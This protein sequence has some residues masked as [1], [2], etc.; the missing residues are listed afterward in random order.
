VIT[1]LPGP[2][3]IP[4]ALALDL[5]AHILDSDVDIAI[6]L[7]VAGRSRL[8]PDSGG[9]D[10]RDR[11]LSGHSDRHQQRGAALCPY[12][13]I[14]RLGEAVGRFLAALDKRVLIVSGDFRTSRRC[15]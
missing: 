4:G 10:R 2:L 13:R 6:S 8:H 9:T 1:S 3:S 7:S 14:R 11:P 15:R 5:A 12:R